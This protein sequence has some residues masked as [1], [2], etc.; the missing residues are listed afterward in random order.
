MTCRK[1]ISFYIVVLDCIYQPIIIAYR[2]K[3]NTKAFFPFDIS[4]GVGVL[5]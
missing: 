4:I 3:V 5:I 2:E 1:F